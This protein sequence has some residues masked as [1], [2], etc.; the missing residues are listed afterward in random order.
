MTASN[1]EIYRAIG[2]L[3]A[4]VTSLRRDIQEDAQNAVDTAKRADDHRAV[5]HKRMDEIITRTGKLE[6]QMEAA[7]ETLG[8]VKDVTDQV[9]RWRLA[10]LGALGVTGIAASAVTA[11]ITAY[12]Q[13]ILRVFSGK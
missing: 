13:D 1:N 5:I 6:G 11:L 3:T 9:T 12:W 7:T 2:Q 10:G 8:E 4:E